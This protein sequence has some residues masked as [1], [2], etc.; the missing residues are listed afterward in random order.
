MELWNG[1][2]LGSRAA[3]T[4]GSKQQI[5]PWKW[6]SLFEQNRKAPEAMYQNKGTCVPGWGQHLGPKCQLCKHTSFSIVNSAC[7]HLV[8]MAI[9]QACTHP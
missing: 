3:T 4:L 7:K 6:S 9:A 1:Q 5:P 8:Q 2:N